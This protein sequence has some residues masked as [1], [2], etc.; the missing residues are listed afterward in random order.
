MNSAFASAVCMNKA[1]ENMCANT[2]EG[3]EV[4]ESCIT[5]T[6]GGHTATSRAGS[7]ACKQDAEKIKKEK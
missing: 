1:R 4:L 7:S 6:A 5:L 2:E 3:E